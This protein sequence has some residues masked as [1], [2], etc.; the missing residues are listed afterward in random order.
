MKAHRGTCNAQA[1]HVSGAAVRVRK[2][3]M[4]AHKDEGEPESGTEHPMQ[5][6]LTLGTNF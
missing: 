6:W 3:A 5:L 1:D 2:T 4:L